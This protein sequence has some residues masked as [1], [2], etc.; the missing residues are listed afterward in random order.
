M[1]RPKKHQRRYPMRDVYLLVRY[2]GAM[3]HA[4][5]TGILTLWGIGDGGLG[6]YAGV[7]MRRPY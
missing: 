5:A 2:Q 1:S 6:R 7:D 3:I 4:R